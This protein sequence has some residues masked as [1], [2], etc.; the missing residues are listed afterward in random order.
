MR[1]LHLGHRTLY[2]HYC[3]A[4]KTDRWQLLSRGWSACLC[5]C[6]SACATCDVY[7]SS[8]ESSTLRQGKWRLA[9]IM[10]NNCSLSFAFACRMRCIC[11]L[12]VI[13]FMQIMNFMATT[14]T[15]Y[16]FDEP[17]ASPSS[18][19]L[20]ATRFFISFRLTQDGSHRAEGASA[21][22]RTKLYSYYVSI[23]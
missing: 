14:C 19:S 12:C 6:A 10:I 4:I 21:G 1:S 22:E 15:I 13:M 2:V 9:M 20:R 17:N 3:E 11:I 23:F 8:V 18:H 5:M 7:L 16:R